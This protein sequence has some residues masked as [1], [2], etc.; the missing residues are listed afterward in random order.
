MSNIYKAFEQAEKEIQFLSE[1][2]KEGQREAIANGKKIGI[3][4]GTTLVTKKSKYAKKIIRQHSIYFGGTL[5]DK[6]IIKLAGI[7]RNSFYKYKREL[8][9]GT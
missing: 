7:S 6:D 9:E 8:M 4:K 5:Q 2:T 1:R 3:S